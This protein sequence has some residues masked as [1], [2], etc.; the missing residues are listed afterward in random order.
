M[1]FNLNQDISKHKVHVY[2]IQMGQKFP[3]MLKKIQGLKGNG[4]IKLVPHCMIFMC[5]YLGN[6]KMID[7]KELLSLFPSPTGR[8]T[9]SIFVSAD[10]FSALQNRLAN[11]NS[12]VRSSKISVSSLMMLMKLGQRRSGTYYQKW[13]QQIQIFIK[14]YLLSARY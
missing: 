12:L 7:G 11:F 2:W 10:H 14:R 5:N 6:L 8:F 1:D 13:I 9:H 4:L 3:C